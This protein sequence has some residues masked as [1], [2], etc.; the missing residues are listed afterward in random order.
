M[1]V[2]EILTLLA[3]VPEGKEVCIKG[4]KPGRVILS[5][6]IPDGPCPKGWSEVNEAS[7]QS[8][9]GYRRIRKD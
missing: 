4:R 5:L 8:I 9:L 6:S 1:D 7:F 3:D 2:K